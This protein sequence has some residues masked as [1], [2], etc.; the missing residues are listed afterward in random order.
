MDNLQFD[1]L[2]N[3]ISQGD[4]DALGALYDATSSNVFGFALSILSDRQLAEDVMH[5][6]YIKIF[7]QAA[8][9]KSQGKAMAWILRITRNTAFNTSKKRNY[10]SLNSFETNKLDNAYQIDNSHD[11][12]LEKLIVDEIL[13]KLPMKERQIIVLH[14]FSDMT[15]KEISEITGVPLP[16]V[17]WRYKSALKKLS[18][19]IEQTQSPDVTS[20]QWII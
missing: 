20:Q 11:T 18:N 15:H 3:K 14:L 17:K 1:N 2:L 13:A 9:Y 4:R 16:T 12:V 7:C 19:E 10:E 8:S 5:D 6:V